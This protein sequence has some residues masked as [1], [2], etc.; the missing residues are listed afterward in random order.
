MKNLLLCAFVMTLTVSFAT[1]KESYI[2]VAINDSIK[3]NNNVPTPK[4]EN[5]I[6]SSK[7]IFVIDGKIVSAQKS[8]EALENN[9]VNII[10]GHEI[11]KN[12][13][14]LYGEKYRTGVII[15]ERKNEEKK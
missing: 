8:Y 2:Y 12:A 11:S 9:E 13:I 10:G 6:D 7:V 14:L 15:M 3:D 5:E 4:S 1:P